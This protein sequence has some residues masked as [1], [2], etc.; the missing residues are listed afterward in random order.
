ANEE[1]FIL[2]IS[3]K[4][5]ISQNTG[6]A[7][8]LIEVLLGKVEDVKW[9]RSCF[10]TIDKLNVNLRTFKKQFLIGKTTANV[11]LFIQY[12]SGKTIPLPF[13]EP[14]TFGYP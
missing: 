12:E 2:N 3:Y 9:Q 5:G 13:K 7:Y 4:E 1:Q 6:E 10:T 8:E 11:G 14:I